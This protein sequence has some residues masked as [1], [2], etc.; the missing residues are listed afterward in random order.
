MKI[1]STS[2]DISLV[3]GLILFLSCLFVF[4]VFEIYF[5]KKKNL[6]HMKG[7]FPLPLFGKLMLLD[8]NY[9]KGSDTLS[10]FKNHVL[11]FIQIV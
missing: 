4:S 2:L 7:P 1:F 11:T 6:W 8:I 9:K 3:Y 10:I 5:D